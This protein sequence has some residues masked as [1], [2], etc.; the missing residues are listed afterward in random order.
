[1]QSLSHTAFF[2]ADDKISFAA[3]A[4]AQSAHIHITIFT[5]VAMD[6]GTE[7]QTLMAT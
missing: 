4:R 6:I 2:T 7:I 5:D 3:Y 1:M